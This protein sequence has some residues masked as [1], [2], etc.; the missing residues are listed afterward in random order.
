M[1]IDLFG[2]EEAPEAKF[3]RPSKYFSAFGKGKSQGGQGSNSSDTDST[4]EAQLN[5]QAQ[6]K[7]NDEYCVSASNE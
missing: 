6:V 4:A 3:K 1:L 7:T 5:G 2:P